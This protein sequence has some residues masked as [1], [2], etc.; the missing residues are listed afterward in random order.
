METEEIRKYLKEVIEILNA[1]QL[2][3]IYQLFRG[4]FGKVL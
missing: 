4:I 2:R 1:A 3:K